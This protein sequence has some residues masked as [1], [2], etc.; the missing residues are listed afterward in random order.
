LETRIEVIC[1]NQ[2]P[3]AFAALSGDRCNCKGISTERKV[4]SET[5]DSEAPA[6]AI[7]D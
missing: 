6:A 3:S 2:C 4:V 7:V 1:G 5:V